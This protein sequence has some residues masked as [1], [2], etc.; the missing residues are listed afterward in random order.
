MNVGLARVVARPD[1]PVHFVQLLEYQCEPGLK[2]SDKD[3]FVVNG[4]RVVTGEAEGK[5]VYAWFRGRGKS[6]RGWLPA[7]HV[8]NL[9]MDTSPILEKWEGTWTVG[10]VRVIVITVDRKTHQLIITANAKWYGAQLENGYQVVHTGDV[11][12]KALP[13]GNGLIIPGDDDAECVLE[14]ELIDEFLAAEDNM[15]CGGMDVS[16]SDV[17]TRTPAP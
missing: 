2:C 12:G 14:L 9:A 4:D 5:L 11:H 15:H 13:D 6:M 17:Y 1:E 8:K 10:D 16:F 3:I 7:A